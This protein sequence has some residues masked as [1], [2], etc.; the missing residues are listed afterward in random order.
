M[1]NISYRDAPSSSAFIL[2]TY[3]Y[4]TFIKGIN[5]LLSKKN[6]LVAI[7]LIV[8]C[9][10]GARASGQ[11]F[12]VPHEFSATSRAAR[13]MVT[14][15]LLKLH[16]NEV[17]EARRQVS[18]DLSAA[19][20]NLI[21]SVVLQQKNEQLF[22]TL[23]QSQAPTLLNSK[24]S[25]KM[26]SKNFVEAITPEQASEVLKMF[27]NHPVISDP[28]SLKYDTPMRQI[29]YCFGRAAF[30]HWE[31]LRRGV[32]PASIGKIFAIGGMFYERKGWSFHV[33]T[34]VRST[35][36]GWLVIDSLQNQILTPQAW[37][38]EVSK[39]A[40]NNDSSNLRYYFT[41]P[42]KFIPTAGAYTSKNL[43]SHY[44]KGYFQDLIKW[45][46]ENP[47]LKS[48]S[49]INGEESKAEKQNLIP[50]KE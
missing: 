47:I 24:S 43:N 31:L 45:F 42:L 5:L 9:D 15:D 41:D 23:S 13:K 8:S 28:A 12:E 3:F 20:Q 48:E 22:K 1:I 2:Q 35:E 25:L 50:S 37:A 39:W 49:F 26:S 38:K 17:I 21:V 4:I 46:R 19:E 44:Y 36:G 40:M 32:S 11:T 30:A 29:G 7:F 14:T 16:E 33:A 27:K 34:I 18:K 6:I 10:E